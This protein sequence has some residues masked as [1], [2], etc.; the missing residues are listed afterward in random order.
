[1]LSK[2]Q[3]KRC[4]ILNVQQLSG[5]FLPPASTNPDSGLNC[6]AASAFSESIWRGSEMLPLCGILLRAKDALYILGTES[7]LRSTPGL[8][9]EPWKWIGSSDSSLSQEERHFYCQNLK[10]HT[11]Q[12]RH[13]AFCQ[14]LSQ[15][16]SKPC[17]L[18]WKYLCTRQQK[19][20]TWLN[21]KEDSIR[22]YLSL[23]SSAVIQN[24]DKGDLREEGLI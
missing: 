1:M 6:E 3:S 13:P 18:G 20:K 7:C 2:S 8:L 4:L 22:L 21:I 11:Q 24:Y 10:W 23:S 16:F 17:C 19:S 14:S 9:R 5:F 15:R 12:K